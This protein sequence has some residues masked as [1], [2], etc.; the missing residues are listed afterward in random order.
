MMTVC[1]GSKVTITCGYCGASVLPVTWI[2]N[3]TSLIQDEVLNSPLYQLNHLTTPGR[4]SLTVLSINGSTTFRCMFHS[5]TSRLGR[6]II[7]GM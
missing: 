3:G 1:R 4:L 5:T 2:I 6:V 7:A